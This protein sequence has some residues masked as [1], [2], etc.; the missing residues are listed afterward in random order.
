MLI[1]LQVSY[2]KNMKIISLN[3]NNFGGSTE[4]KP[5]QDDIKY[6]DLPKDYIGNSKEIYCD[7]VKKFQRDSKRLAVAEKI[8]QKMV[9]ENPDIII[10]HEYDINSP[11]ND[12]LKNLLEKRG[13]NLIPP[14]Q[15][16]YNTIKEQGTRWSIS[17]IFIKKHFKFSTFQSPTTYYARWNQIKIGNLTLIGIHM[18]YDMKFWN[19]LITFYKNNKE[20][21]LLFMGDFNATDNPRNDCAKKVKEE[22][23]EVF[24]QGAID[25]WIEKGNRPIKTFI[26]GTRLDYAIVSP[27][28]LPEITNIEIDQFFIEEKISDHA[29]VNVSLKNQ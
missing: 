27:I 6:A 17:V 26:I 20:E 28:V 18:K 22:F 29:A 10:F 14:N 15:I 3:I 16:A 21:H 2:E 23:D 9:E 13:Y 11:A 25:V 19:E 5:R 4:C 24:A 12:V 7:D 1:T 8:Y